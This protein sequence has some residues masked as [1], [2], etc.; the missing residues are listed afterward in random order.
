MAQWA[1]AAR[2]RL[3]GRRFC[4]ISIRQWQRLW[5]LLGA[6][7]QLRSGAGEAAAGTSW[8]TAWSSSLELGAAAWGADV[9]LRLQ[10]LAK[11]RPEAQGSCPRHARHSGAPL[12][13]PAR[14]LSRAKQLPGLLMLH[15]C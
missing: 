5:A 12:A 9:E 4:S 7:Q 10:P 2:G 3:A 6:T 8:N 15:V 13:W 11:Q 1:R 14:P